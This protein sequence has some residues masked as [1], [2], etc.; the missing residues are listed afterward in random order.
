M[1]VAGRRP[2]ARATGAISIEAGA[3]MIAC[4]RGC[5]EIGG[6]A[7]GEQ[8]AATTASAATAKNER[9]TP[10]TVTVHA[11]PVKRRLIFFRFFLPVAHRLNVEIDH[12]LHHRG[13]LLFARRRP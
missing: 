8:A 5:A 11:S 13:A 6:G 3:V 12:A 7:A 9:F 10:R 4:E 1:T 2:S